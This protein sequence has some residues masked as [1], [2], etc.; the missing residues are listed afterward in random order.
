MHPPKHTHIYTHTQTHTHMCMPT[1]M[2]SN[3][4]RI[5]AQACIPQNTHT[6]THTHA[7]LHAVKYNQNY[8]TSMHLPKHTHTHTRARACPHMHQQKHI[9]DNHAHEG[10]HNAKQENQ[11]SLN[12]EKNPPCRHTGPPVNS[13]Y[14]LYSPA[15]VSLSCSQ[16]YQLHL[17]TSPA[18]FPGTMTT[19][20]SVFSAIFVFCFFTW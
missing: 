5:I 12:Q 8:C 13:L 18:P 4:T 11:T 1:Y 17:V 19:L 10:N 9:H 2:P 16:P 7:H 20:T 14:G 15:L 6:H 3:T